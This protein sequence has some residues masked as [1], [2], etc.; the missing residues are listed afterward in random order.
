[1]KLPYVRIRDSRYIGSFRQPQ[2]GAV[3]IPDSISADDYRYLN[4]EF[5]SGSY[6]VTVDENLKAEKEDK[7]S[8]QSQ[9]D[10]LIKA[11]EIELKDKIQSNLLKSDP[12]FVLLQI[13]TWRDMAARPQAYFDQGIKSPEVLRDNG[14]NVLFGLGDLINTE[15]KVLLYAN[16]KLQQVGKFYIWRAKRLDQLQDDI[17]AIMGV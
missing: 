3:V 6:A 7:A 14:G 10:A 4:V 16:R 12:M 11:Y 5:I 1:M 9:K 8:K 13:D 17:N 2:K 15:E